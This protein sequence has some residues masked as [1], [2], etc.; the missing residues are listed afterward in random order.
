M[1]EKKK[2]GLWLGGVSRDHA[3]THRSGVRLRL[4][5]RCRAKAPAPGGEGR[6][7]HWIDQHF[8]LI[9]ISNLAL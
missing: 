2:G 1:V 4:R 5:H 7:G 3:S 9:I 8:G 6:P